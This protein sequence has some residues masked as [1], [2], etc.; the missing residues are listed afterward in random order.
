MEM[1]FCRR[2]VSSRWSEI[3]CGP[4]S[5][6][7]IDRGIVNVVCLVTGLPTVFSS[8]DDIVEAWSELA[9]VGI[10]VKGD[11]DRCYLCEGEQGP[12]FSMYE[13]A[14]CYACPSVSKH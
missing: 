13:C 9:P 7:V 4:S 3:C 2:S 12:L 1:E 8:S 14:V 11:Q 5:W 6:I 10:R